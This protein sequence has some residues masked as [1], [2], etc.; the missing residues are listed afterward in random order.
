[1]ADWLVFA[2]D[3]GVAAQIQAR[4]AALDK[5]TIIVKRGTEFRELSETEFEID[6][7]SQVDVNKVLDHVAGK[8]MFQGLIFLWGLDSVPN[9]QLSIHHILE[10]EGHS[11]RTMMNV[12]KKLNDSNYE[13]NPEIWMITS[14]AQSVGGSPET[15]QLSQAGLRG[16]NKVILNEFPV[17]NS[18]MVDFS[19]PVGEDELDAFVEEIL[20]GDNEDEIAFRGRKR[21][22]NR[23]E[24]ISTDNIAQ[25]AL[26][27]L[28]AEESPYTLTIDDYGVLDHLVIR[29]TDRKEPGADEVEVNIR[30]SA[31]NFRDIMLSMGLL[32]DDAING[33]LFGKTMGLECSGVISAVGKDVQNLKVGD[34]IMA[35]APSCLGKFAYP[36]ACHVVRKP[37][38]ISFQDAATLPVVYVTAYYSL[39]YLCR[40]RRGEK[41]LIHAAAGGVGIAAIHIAKAAGAEI[42]AT[43]GSQEKRAYVESIGVQ[44]DH[45]LNS[46]T[47][48]FADQLM[49]LTGGEGVDIVLNSLSGEAIYKSIRCLSPYGRFVEIGKTDIYRN[50]KLGLQ[51]FGNN[52]SYFGVDV[53]RLFK[54]K[55]IFSGELF[56]EAIDYFVENSFPVH[57]TVVF[58]ISQNQGCFPVYGRGKAYW[59]DHH[60][61]GR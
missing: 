22:I 32:S 1:M 54:Q 47:L 28:S 20:A 27:T 18:T 39:V 50:S 33:G 53:D 14:G 60:Q 23:L 46:R 17:Y 12:M 35:T 29:E 41:I 31:L 13:K 9:E 52:L 30:A 37:A 7:G 25:R 10:A 59:Q 51:P 56:Q 19:T 49:E 57:P 3:S 15:V 26:R 61:H 36:K 34:E 2:D 48:E 40:I 8:K 6:P 55:E 4:L 11:S 16:V 42:F 5:R 38:H 45:I 43:V 24:R 21:Y 58:P 44:P